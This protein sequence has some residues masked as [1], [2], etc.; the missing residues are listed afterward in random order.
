MKSADRLIQHGSGPTTA[1]GRRALRTALQ[2]SLHTVC[3]Q[4]GLG[5]FKRGSGIERGTHHVVWRVSTSDGDFAIRASSKTAQRGR[6]RRERL[7]TIVGACG[8][9]PKY[10]GSVRIRKFGFDGWLEAFDWVQGRHLRPSADHIE[11]AR[12]LALLH[13]IPIPRDA[14]LTP[15]L[16]LIRFLKNSLTR[17]LRTLRGRNAV[18][19]LL[20]AKTNASL[21]LLSELPRVSDTVAIVHN[22]L[23]DGNVISHANG[24]AIIDWDWAMITQP[25]MDLF[26]FLSP[27]VR[28][29]RSMPR[30]VSVSTAVEFIDEYRRRVRRSRSRSAPLD[31]SGWRPYN[32]LIANWLRRQKEAPP[33]AASLAFYKRSFAEVDELASIIGR[34]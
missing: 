31:L 15:R 34:D 12:T 14:S 4:L 29:W 28:S 11:L 17:D 22:D 27:F 13:L 16:G 24:V 8:A 33:H 30:Y 3:N 7:W 32:A 6:T 19:R 21:E 10:I 23:V 20:R 1:R 2:P 9:A 5:C 26:C 18:D 25:E